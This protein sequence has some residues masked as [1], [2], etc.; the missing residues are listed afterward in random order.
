M[1]RYCQFHEDHDHNIEECWDLRKK[2]PELIKARHL[3]EYLTE[4]GREITTEVDNNRH[5]QNQALVAMRKKRG[6]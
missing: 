5:T 1:S 3:Q 2:V 4:K 6:S